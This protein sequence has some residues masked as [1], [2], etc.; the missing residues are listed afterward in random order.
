MRKLYFRIRFID[1]Y[2]CLQFECEKHTYLNYT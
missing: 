2:V 1:K